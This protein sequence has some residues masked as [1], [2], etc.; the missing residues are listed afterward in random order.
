MKIRLPKRY[1]QLQNGDIID[2]TVSTHKLYRFFDDYL[3]VGTF[4]LLP[5]G[6]PIQNNL[7]YYSGGDMSLATFS[8]DLP[9][10]RWENFGPIKKEFDILEEEEE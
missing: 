7:S 8:T 4:I 9:I 1:V 5:Y 3:Y 6:L 10:E 2:T